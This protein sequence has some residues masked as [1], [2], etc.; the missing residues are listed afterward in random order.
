MRPTK[1]EVDGALHAPYT[2]ALV[3]AREVLALR[4]ELHPRSPER[5]AMRPT[6]DAVDAALE[7]TDLMEFAEMASQSQSVLAAEVLAL[8]RYVADLENRLSVFRNLM[9]DPPPGER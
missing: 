1:E 6:K 9:T 8:R 4:E 7:S 3:L 5:N 2:H